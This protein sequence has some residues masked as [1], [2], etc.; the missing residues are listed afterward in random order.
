MENAMCNDDYVGNTVP[1]TA[2]YSPSSVRN[3]HRTLPLPRH[4]APLR[5]CVYALPSVLRL[6]SAILFDY[7]LSA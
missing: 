7:R 3:V 4:T 5:Q 1:V 6:W 2:S